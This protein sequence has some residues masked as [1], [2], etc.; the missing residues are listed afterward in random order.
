M[1]PRPTSP[2]SPG[3][4]AASARDD[5]SDPND[6]ADL[7]ERLTYIGRIAWREAQLTAR[8]VWAQSRRLLLFGKSWWTS[9]RLEA[10]TL[11]A[12][13]ALGERL[14]E[15]DLGDAGLRA[16][17][18]ELRERR[19]SFAAAK[20]STRGIDAEIRGLCARLAEPFL[21]SAK[22]PPAVEEQ[23]RQALSLR[24]EIAN[25]RARQTE[26]RAALFPDDAGM[27]IRTAI[28]VGLAVIFLCLIGSALFRDRSAAGYLLPAKIDLESLQPLA[29]FPMP[30]D[31]PADGAGAVK[32]EFEVGADRFLPARKVSVTFVNGKPDGEVR[33]VSADGKVISIEH[34]RNGVLNGLRQRFYPNGE[35]FSE[36]RFDNGVAQGTEYVYFLNGLLASKTDIIDGLPHGTSEIYFDNGFPCVRSP[37]VGGLLDGQRSHYRPDD[38]C[39]AIVTW[40][41]GK[42][43]SQQFL[44]LEVTSADVAEIQRRGEFST[45]LVDHWE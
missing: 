1:S 20:E 36:L 22:S 9:R 34:Y 16:R 4:G 27:R 19:K 30:T 17:L 8:A 21:E 10:K 38:V 29:S 15:V 14:V 18:A 25:R 45:R 33:S 42:L 13:I 44:Q 39:F 31:L 7:R 41:E 23:H 28:G 40:S 24:M 2:N 11:A 6:L 5:A 32:R 26:R 12:Q 3:D 37:Y 35:R 43:V